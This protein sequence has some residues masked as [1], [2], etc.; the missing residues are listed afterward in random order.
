MGQKSQSTTE[1]LFDVKRARERMN[2]DRE[3]F[4]E[5]VEL[6]LKDYVL[7]LREIDTALRNNDANQLFHSAHTLKG[8]VANF[9]A[10]SAYEKALK[11]EKIGQSTDLSQGREVFSAL[12]IEVEKLATALRSE[13]EN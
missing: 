3:L 12:E 4:K 6:F 5:V 13:I 2:N 11:L 10:K 9:V 8:S 7:R 1:P